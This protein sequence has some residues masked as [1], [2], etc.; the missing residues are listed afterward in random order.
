[1]IR[2]T[3]RECGARLESKSELAGKRDQ[4]PVCGCQCNVPIRRPL[5]APG[6]AVAIAS[7]IVLLLVT[8][9]WIAR[10]SQKIARTM[11][12]TARHSVARRTRRGVLHSTPKIEFLEERGPSQA[13]G[14]YYAWVLIKPV[15]KPELRKLGQRLLARMRSLQGDHLKV[16]A[17]YSRADYAVGTSAV[18]LNATAPQYD[19]RMSGPV[20]ESTTP[21]GLYEAYVKWDP[22]VSTARVKGPIWCEY[23][24]E[25]GILV[26]HD[27]WSA[28]FRGRLHMPAVVLQMGHAY[29][30][31]EIAHPCWA[32]IPGLRRV[33]VHHYQKGDPTPVLTVS[34]GRAAF[35]QAVRLNRSLWKQRTPLGEL[36]SRAWKRYHAKV[37]TEQEYK[38]VADSVARQLYKLY[39]DLWVAVSPSV[40]IE[41]HRKMSAPPPEFFRK[42]FFGGS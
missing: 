21:H 37:M 15:P 29:L 12:S 39:E 18:W 28:D 5:R 13:Y 38:A 35:D 7:V 9:L 14:G 25:D 17:H 8:A 1:M 42:Y 4:C 33:V 30:P 22:M 41:V 34:F 27:A 6:V 2:F 16:W 24:P 36:E 23:K 11:P 10:R 31:P 20:P 40:R 26:Y 3:C 19:V 32:C